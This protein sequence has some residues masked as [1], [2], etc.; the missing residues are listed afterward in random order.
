[1][2]SKG[3]GLSSWNRRTK[4]CVR[5][6]FSRCPRLRWRG[7]SDDRE[8]YLAKQSISKTHII[9]YKVVEYAYERIE[10]SKQARCEI[11][12]VHQSSNNSSQYVASS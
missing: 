11:D 12:E 4:K 2:S 6:Y 8:S 1:M 7:V 3:G 10:E 5:S 9:Y